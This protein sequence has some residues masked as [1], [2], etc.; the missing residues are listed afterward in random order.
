MGTHGLCCSTSFL[1][2]ASAPSHPYRA[3][4]EQ[5]LHTSHTPTANSAL[6]W[7]EFKTDLH[8][9]A[10]YS[11]VPHSHCFTSSMSK[12]HPRL[13]TGWSSVPPWMCQVWP[14]FQWAQYLTQTGSHNMA[15]GMTTGWNQKG[16][17]HQ[18]W[19]ILFAVIRAW[20]QVFSTIS[21]ITK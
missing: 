17:R 18:F 1:L 6:G 9:N 14:L 7:K 20:F 5:E 16:R 2:T 21:R 8:S 19:R 11:W 12:L 13:G 3:V 10:G 4:S 15:V